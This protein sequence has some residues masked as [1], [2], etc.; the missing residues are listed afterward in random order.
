MLIFLYDSCYIS[1]L[2]KKNYI[3]CFSLFQ[4]NY[5]KN[6]PIEK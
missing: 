3:D 5:K 1:F 6:E 4:K 2:N